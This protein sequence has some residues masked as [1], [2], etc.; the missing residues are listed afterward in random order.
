[1]K[2]IY[3]SGGNLRFGRNGGL[4]LTVSTDERDLKIFLT[5][6]DR[7]IE[8]FQGVQP[9]CSRALFHQMR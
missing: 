2:G 1:M 9:A 8:I 5:K 7:V 6:I 4:N 3:I